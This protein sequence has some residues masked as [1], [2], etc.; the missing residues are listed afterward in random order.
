MRSKYGRPPPATLKVCVVPGCAPERNG[1]KQPAEEGTDEQELES[2]TV[3][4]P[5]GHA[6]QDAEPTG[7][8]CARGHTT[9]ASAAVFPRA[10]ED[11]PAGQLL[12]GWEEALP[13]FP[14]PHWVH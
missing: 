8:K 9:H 13:N 11:R 4:F 7:A 10:A 3:H 1:A 2:A 14:C 12:H 6:V 5:G